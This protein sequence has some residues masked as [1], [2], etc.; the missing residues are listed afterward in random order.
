[1]S[2]GKK[3]SDD[4]PDDGKPGDHPDMINPETGKDEGDSQPE[5]NDYPDENMGADDTPFGTGD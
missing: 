3:N 1:M 5:S 2:G 4:E